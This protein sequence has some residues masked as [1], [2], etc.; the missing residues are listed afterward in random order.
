MSRKGFSLLELLIYTGLFAAAAGLLTGIALTVSRVQTSE[1]ASLTVNREAEFVL[2]RIQNLV[3]ESSSIEDPVCDGDICSVK[4]RMED[5]SL[6]PTCLSIESGQV[7]LSQGPGT[8]PDAC[9]TTKVALTTEK[10]SAVAFDL[11]KVA[12]PGGH[13]IL[14]VDLTLNYSSSNPG[15]AAV[16]KTLTSAIARVSAAT[17]D[18]N[19]LPNA[20]NTL[21]I[22]GSG[23]TWKNILV[24]NV[25][26]SAPSYSFGLSSTSGIYSP[27][28]N[29]IGISTAGTERIRIDASGNVGIGTS[30]PSSI[31][32]LGGNAARLI[33]ME[34]HTTANT[35]GNNLTVQAGGATSGAT[36]KSGGALI[37]KSGVSTGTGTGEIQFWTSPA[38]ITGT[39]DNASVLRMTINGSGNIALGGGTPTYKITN[40]AEPTANSDA[41][42]KNYVDTQTSLGGTPM[43]KLIMSG[44][45]AGPV[46][47][48]TGYTISNIPSGNTRMRLIISFRET[49]G[50]GGVNNYRVQFNGDAASNYYGAGYYHSSGSASMT[51]TSAATSTSFVVAPFQYSSDTW[52]SIEMD[53]YNNPTYRKLIWA[54]G[55]QTGSTTA[56]VRSFHEGSWNNT[57]NEISSIRIFGDGGFSFN[58]TDIK[59]SIYSY[60]L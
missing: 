51:F 44:T 29:V 10:V 7:K 24:A 11:S 55:A 48:Q 60:N 9:S 57:T 30:S 23:T 39:A 35:A 8:S 47:A 41:A 56:I 20:D 58:I 13:S 19:L 28:T 27:A 25:L 22:G 21:S 33:G 5:A 53:I 16:S 59:Y 18:S 14:N 3:R 38:G 50:G 1:S 4:L 42:T 54:N 32:A 40:L 6:D 49:F 45:E 43:L 36:D 12:N 15:L 52:Q 37:L 31:L 17:F 34:R 26:V 46:V 2:Q